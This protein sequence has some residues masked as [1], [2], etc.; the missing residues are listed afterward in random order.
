M[1]KF[2]SFAALALSTAEAIKI[3]EMSM[4]QD[5]QEHHHH[6]GLAQEATHHVMYRSGGTGSWGLAQVHAKKHYRSGTAHHHSSTGHAQLPKSFSQLLQTVYAQQ[7]PARAP[8][9][10]NTYCDDT[11]C[12]GPDGALEG[13]SPGV[14]GP[15]GAGPP[16]PM[17]PSP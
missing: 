1:I 4:A 17:P 6:G 5:K 8:D 13:G 10:T 3:K 11:G 12:Y 9:D 2:T 15:G 16:P 14:G 7:G